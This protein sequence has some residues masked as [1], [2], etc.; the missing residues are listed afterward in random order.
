M[1][2]TTPALPARQRGSVLFVALMLLIVIALLG[3]ASMQTTTIQERMAGN[4]RNLNRA[5]QNSERTVRTV[6][7]NISTLTQA[8][9]AVQPSRLTAVNGTTPEVTTATCADL[10]VFNRNTWAKNQSA[11][12]SSSRVSIITRCV[13]AG[14]ITV[15]G[16][17]SNRLE[18][19]LVTGVGQTDPADITTDSSSV[20]IETI[21]I[22]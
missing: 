1:K 22:P 20:A 8:G 10:Q 7:R 15:R 16:P 19:Y 4:Y 17:S 13:A 3:I 21:Y 6:E 9:T 11:T 12:A 14:D 2:R 5:F 18:M